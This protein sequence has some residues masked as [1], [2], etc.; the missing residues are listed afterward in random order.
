MYEIV[1]RRMT[2]APAV[3]QLRQ[4][5]HQA[6]TWDSR[7][8]TSAKLPGCVAAFCWRVQTRSAAFC[9]DVTRRKRITSA[10]ALGRE[11][12]AWRG[13]SG[14]DLA[15]NIHGLDVDR[16]SWAPCCHQGLRSQAVRRTGMTTWR[17]QHGD[18]LVAHLGHDEISGLYRVV[19]WCEGEEQSRRRPLPTRWHARRSSIGTRPSCADNG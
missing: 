3:A 9:M 18:K 1:A 16:L 17:R 19:V 14:E 8:W 12:T 11:V 2:R 10:I 13:A 6:L 5:V 15:R 4:Y 7:V